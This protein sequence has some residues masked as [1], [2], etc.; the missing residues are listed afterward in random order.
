MRTSLIPARTFSCIFAPTFQLPITSS[1]PLLLHRNRSGPWLFGY[2]L[3]PFPTAFFS[4]FWTQARYS[5]GVCRVGRAAREACLIPRGRRQQ[6]AGGWEKKNWGRPRVSS[7]S[8]FVCSGRA[9]AA[10]LGQSS[11]Q[12]LGV[13]RVHTSFPL[14]RTLCLLPAPTFVPEPVPRLA[15]PSLCQTKHKTFALPDQTQ[16]RGLAQDGHRKWRPDA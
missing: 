9:S 14:T 5:I 8:V 16:R 10:I 2:F 13:R 3:L 12:L 4:C 1:V 15:Q 6:E 7:L 11:A